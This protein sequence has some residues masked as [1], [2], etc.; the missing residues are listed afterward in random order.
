MIEV[1][2]NR[3]FFL[4]LSLLKVSNIGRL[5][6]KKIGLLIMIDAKNHKDMVTQTE[7][8]KKATTDSILRSIS[9]S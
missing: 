5:L 1:A 6:Q 8:S 9:M 2:R 4:K 3:S 7:V